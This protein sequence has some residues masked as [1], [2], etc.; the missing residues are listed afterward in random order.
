M[1]KTTWAN[2]LLASPGN[3][4]IQLMLA[5]SHMPYLPLEIHRCRSR[6]K[7]T[8]T[9]LCFFF[10]FFF[11]F[12]GSFTFSQIHCQ[13]GGF[14]PT[15]TP[16]SRREPPPQVHY[17]N[18]AHFEEGIVKSI[19]L[20]G[21]RS[22]NVK[23]AL[24]LLRRK[25]SAPFPPTLPLFL[26]IAI[27]SSSLLT[28]TTFSSQRL[29]SV[30]PNLSTTHTKR[31]FPSSPSTPATLDERNASLV[32]TL[33]VTT[34]LPSL[35]SSTNSLCQI[36]Q[37]PLVKIPIPSQLHPRPAFS[38]PCPSQVPHRRYQRRLGDH[39]DWLVQGHIGP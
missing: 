32:L 16:S 8:R 10:F 19:S 21:P 12:F 25:Y 9:H 33:K 31:I 17:Q 15:S 1:C 26:L 37:P 36:L 30:T 14:L 6:L 34:S 3:E 4:N 38:T 5:N 18:S 2:S 27:G 39:Q 23:F 35:A 20:H 28:Q 7:V 13:L 24:Q 29:L 11:L 22:T